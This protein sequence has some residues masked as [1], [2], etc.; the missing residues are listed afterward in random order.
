VARLDFTAEAENDLLDIWN[1]IAEDNPRA[2]DRI[3]RTIGETCARLAENPGL[4]PA[5][6][7]I[8]ADLR[9]LPTGNYLIFYRQIPEGTEIVRVLHGARNIEAIFPASSL[10]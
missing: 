5:R 7:E 6:P 8:A 10:H 3:L 1:Y 2:A 4:G 9:Y